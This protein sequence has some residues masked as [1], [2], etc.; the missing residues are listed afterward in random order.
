VT[1]RAAGQSDLENRLA[2]PVTSVRITEPSPWHLLGRLAW[3]Y[4]VD[5]SIDPRAVAD[6]GGYGETSL[7]VRGGDARGV[8]EAAA[9]AVG[10][11]LRVDPGGL[12]LHRAGDRAEPD[13]E[14]ARVR[15]REAEGVP[16]RE[17]GGRVVD[18]RSRPVA[19]ALVATE[20]R[21][22]VRTDTDGRFRCRVPRDGGRVRAWMAGRVPSAP[23]EAA[24]EPLELRIGPPVAVVVVRP[25]DAESGDPVPDALVR[26]EAGDDARFLGPT[27]RDGSVEIRD[28]RAGTVALRVA[29]RGH[30]AA[31]YTVAVRAGE[32][33][34][35]TLRLARA[36]LAERLR[37]ERLAVKTENQPL[38]RALWE[39]AQRAALPIRFEPSLPGG[40]ARRPVSVD[41]GSAAAGEILEALCEAGSVKARI[42]EDA[43]LIRIGAR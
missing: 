6:L 32:V 34:T 14:P 5:L 21:P 9:D 13:H 27:R 38:G 39:F 41:L 19:G 10:L 24:S 22:P 33:T 20:G 23:V 42:D 43:A 18:S 26:S 16:D 25:V 37:T 1:C 35:V 15:V 28:L 17:A 8:L 29:G 12:V 11:R 36:T 3:R 2:R 30:G 31:A 7:D 4:G 40:S